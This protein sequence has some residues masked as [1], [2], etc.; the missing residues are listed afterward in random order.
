MKQ[1]AVLGLGRFGRSLARTLAELGHDVL[2]VDSDA[3]IVEEMS[4]C[5][6]NCVQA[7]IKDEAALTALGLRNFDVVVVRSAGT[8]RRALLPPCS[9]RRWAYTRWCAR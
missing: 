5:L 2:G 8:Y 1:I 6:T 9:S 7:D 4:T 3:A